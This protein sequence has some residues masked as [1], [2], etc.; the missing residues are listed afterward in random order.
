VRDWP[1]CAF[2][3]INRVRACGIGNIAFLADLYHL[4]RTGRAGLPGL[5]RLRVQA[6]RSGG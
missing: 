2:E 1:L 5:D 3:V 6:V 4:G